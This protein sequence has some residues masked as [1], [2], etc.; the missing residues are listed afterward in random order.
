MSEIENVDSG[1]EK[2]MMAGGGVMIDDNEE[3]EEMR[4]KGR[5]ENVGN[6]LKSMYLLLLKM[7]VI[8]YIVN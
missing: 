3:N 7:Y 1:E 6:P 4:S 8:I 5:E 2:E